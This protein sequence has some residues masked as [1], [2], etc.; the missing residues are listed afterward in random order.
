VSSSKS[1]G[2]MISGSDGDDDDDS[3]KGDVNDND[4]SAAR[5]PRAMTIMMT[6][7]RVMSTT[8]IGWHDIW[9]RWR[10]PTMTAARVTSTM[11]TIVQQ[12]LGG[13]DN[14]DSGKGDVNDDDDSVARA[15]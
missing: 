11:M 9:P 5:A 12:G 15:A 10:R 8:M 13:D 6:A 4:N 7:A 3:G 2:G 14:G 1:K